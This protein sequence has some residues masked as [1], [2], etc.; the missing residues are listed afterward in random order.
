MKNLTKYVEV[1]PGVFMA[2]GQATT[3]QRQTKPL[4]YKTAEGK[5]HIKK[6]A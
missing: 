2:A 5:I 3:E 6:E 1:E 4:V